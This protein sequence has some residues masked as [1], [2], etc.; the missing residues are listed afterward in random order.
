LRV[1]DTYYPRG[2]AYPNWFGQSYVRGKRHGDFDA[3]ALAQRTINIQKNAA[4]AYILGFRQQV[5]ET[6]TRYPDR[7][8]QPHI[9]ATHGAPLR[10][11]MLHRVFSSQ[12]HE[13]IPS[14]ISPQIAGTTQRLEDVVPDLLIHQQ[15]ASA[16][17]AGNR[18]G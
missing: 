3:G 1:L 10:S 14:Q 8:R 15:F 4:G 13:P 18:L 5:A 9:E 7:C 12:M 2:E 16:K 6:I 17:S 11:G